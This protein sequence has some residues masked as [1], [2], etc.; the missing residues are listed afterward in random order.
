MARIPPLLLTALLATTAAI[1]PAI[2]GT[3]TY[4]GDIDAGANRAFF[5]GVADRPVTELA[6]TSMG[7]SVEAAITLGR[8]VHGHGVDVVVVG[9]CLSACANYVFPAGRRKVIRPGA[10]VAWHGSYRHLVETGLWRDDAAARMARHG[11]DAA[12]ARTR[13]R[14]A[15]ERLAALEDAFFADIGVDGHL[16]WVGKMPPYEVPDYYTLPVADMARFG[17]TD[18]EAPAGHPPTDLSRVDAHITPI[19]LDAGPVR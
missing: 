19:E 2:A 8:W 3:A 5:E 9:H 10:V 13:A 14:V 11:E 12:T 1:P 6:I 7:G 17:V 16:A 18:I 15:A 4:R